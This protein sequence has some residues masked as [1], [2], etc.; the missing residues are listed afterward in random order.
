[1]VHTDAN[2]NARGTY[3]PGRLTIYGLLVYSGEHRQAGCG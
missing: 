2:A 1:M 3:V